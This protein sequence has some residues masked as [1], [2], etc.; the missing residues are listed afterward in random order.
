[1]AGTI[2]PSE[3]S[4]FLAKISMVSKAISGIFRGKQIPLAAETP[5]LKPVYDPGPSEIATADKSLGDNFVFLNNLSI[6]T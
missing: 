5:I 1:M 6:K 3:H 4:I 2:Y